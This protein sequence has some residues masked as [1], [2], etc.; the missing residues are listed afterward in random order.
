MFSLWDNK[1]INGHK[2]NTKYTFKISFCIWQTNS[3]KGST[4]LQLVRCIT[5][6]VLN[7]FRILIEGE[8]QQKQR[9]MDEDTRVWDR[10]WPCHHLV[11]KVDK[12][13]SIKEYHQN[14]IIKITSRLQLVLKY[15]KSELV[16]HYCVVSYIYSFVIKY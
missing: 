1:N 3:I 9:H 10:G 16:F 14:H 6:P 7:C 12:F 13:H 11:M 8:V 2:Y 4:I 15:W 5:D